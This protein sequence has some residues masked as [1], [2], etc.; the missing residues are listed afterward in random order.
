L[1]SNV[2][3]TVTSFAAANLKGTSIPAPP[4]AAAA[5]VQPK[6]LAHALSRA[7]L[8]G[9]ASLGP[10]IR[11]GKAL[12]LYGNAQA[13]ASWRYTRV[14]ILTVSGLVQIGAAR[15]DQDDAIVERFLQPWQ[16]TLSS[17]I[18]VAMKARAAVRASR[19]ELDSA[20][21]T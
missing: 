11:L 13:K 19:L 15:L 20:K 1:S 12:D 21:Q 3:H 17:S 5:K 8:S 4:V 6:T 7:A 14:R 9:A 10:D 2:A 18:A 16:V